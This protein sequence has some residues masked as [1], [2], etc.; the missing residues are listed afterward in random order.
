MKKNLFL[1]LIAAGQAQTIIPQFETFESA[2]PAMLF[3]TRYKCMVHSGN[4]FL[5]DNY[6]RVVKKTLSDFGGSPITVASTG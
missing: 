3:L 1:L 2:E 6:N 4:Y 5:E